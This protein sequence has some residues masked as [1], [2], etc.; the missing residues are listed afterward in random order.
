[1][2]SCGAMRDGRWPLRAMVLMLAV[3][4]AGGWLAGCGGGPPA[5]LAALPPP[6][7]EQFGAGVN[8]LFTYPGHSATE[9]ASQ[10]QA[11]R[12]TGATLARTDSLWEAT[13]P[14]PPRDGRHEYDWR[15]DDRVAGDLAAAGLRWLP[16]IDYTPAWAQSLPGQ[17][18]SPPVHDSDYAAYAQA[19][20]ARYGTQGAFWKAHPSLPQLPVETYEI[21]NE[22][23][24]PDFWVPHPDPARYARMYAAARSAIRAEQ[25]D[26]RV[27]VGG[28]DNLTPFLPD[29]LSAD[30][31]LRREIDGIALHPYAPAPQQVISQVVTTRHALS[32]LGL[33]GV[34]L[35]VT[36]WGWDTSPPGKPQYASAQER[37]V[38]IALILAALDH[39]RCG[40]AAMVLYTWTTPD[41]DP[42]NPQ[43]WYGINPPGGGGG[44]DVAAFTAGLRAAAEPGPASGC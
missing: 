16:I 21:W 3:L 25:P 36:E 23:D 22:P 18:H 41:T 37:P 24:N 33:G 10:L 2:T 6:A 1:M 27:L 26:A 32:R 17:E 11:L 13:E 28:L 7:D 44:A 14:A 12:D 4:A 43:D 19:F 30:P 15:F 34:P 8:Y 40:V 39:R 9:I 38:W 31:A 42:E 35:Y 29:M 5:R 20:A